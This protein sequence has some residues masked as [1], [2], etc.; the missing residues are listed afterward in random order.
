[1]TEK[2]FLLAFT[3]FFTNRYNL[4]GIPDKVRT[5]QDFLDKHHKHYNDAAFTLR[6]TP[7]APSRPNHNVT[8]PRRKRG[9]DNETDNRYD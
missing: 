5:V 9:L 7:N 8:R 1:M 4:L 2:E 3:E 6:D